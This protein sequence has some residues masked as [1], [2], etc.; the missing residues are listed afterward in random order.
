[1]KTKIEKKQTKWTNENVISDYKRKLFKMM[2]NTVISLIFENVE[3]NN[4]YVGV[5]WLIFIFKFRTN[6]FKNKIPCLGII[7]ALK[8]KNYN[9]KNIFC[10]WLSFNINQKSFNIIIYINYSVITNVILKITYK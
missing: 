8:Y 5:V 1:M 3:T 9:I 4:E 7:M 6:L 2:K 10:F